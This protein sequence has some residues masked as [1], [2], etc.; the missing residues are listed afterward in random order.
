MTQVKERLRIILTE[1]ADMVG[2]GDGR[3]PIKEAIQTK[4]LPS[5]CY[6]DTP[7]QSRLTYSVEFR[8][9]PVVVML[10]VVIGGSDIFE[11]S[12]NWSASGTLLP[13]EAMVL[14]DRLTQVSLLACRVENHLN[15]LFRK[16][17]VDDSSKALF[18]EQ[19]SD[20]LT[21]IGRELEAQRGEYFLNRS[22]P[23]PTQPHNE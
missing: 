23:N 21:E 9:E 6:Y 13:S 22:N 16:Y 18:R 14:T 12:V 15:R 4:A 8:G 19:Y 1:V 2:V 17:R 7:A 10:R 5:I 3:G 20:A 11:V